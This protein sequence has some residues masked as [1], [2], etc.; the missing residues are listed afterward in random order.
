MIALP[1]RALRIYTARHRPHRPAHVRQRLTGMRSYA[2]APHQ[3]ARQPDS[4]VVAL[5]PACCPGVPRP[6]SPLHF[7]RPAISM[8]ATHRVPPA[9]VRR[10]PTRDAILRSTPTSGPPH[11]S[12]VSLSSP[13]LNA[14]GALA[15]RLA[16]ALPNPKPLSILT[17]VADR[18][19]TITPPRCLFEKRYDRFDPC[20]PSG[21]NTQ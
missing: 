21:A 2:A 11:R 6:R 18:S 20:F 7:S 17:A 4:S 10:R 5:C 1:P 12:P 8:R 14:R 15:T 9:H 19:S 3:W 13:G 16:L